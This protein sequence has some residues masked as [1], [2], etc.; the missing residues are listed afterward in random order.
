MT[1]LSKTE[2]AAV[3]RAAASPMLA[4]TEAWTA[5]N[6]GTRNLAGLSRMAD[7]LAD[8]FSALPGHL[9]L[10]EPEPAES[11]TA[12]G[13][14]QALAHG[15]HLHLAVRPEAPVQILLTDHMDTIYGADHPF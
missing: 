6:S 15:H 8:A 12:D 1:E 2:C 11:M 14:V 3:E 7:A 10:V 4:R 9:A 5:I 13:Q